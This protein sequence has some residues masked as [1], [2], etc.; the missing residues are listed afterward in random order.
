MWSSYMEIQIGQIYAKCFVI[1]CLVSKTLHADFIALKIQILF[2]L[3]SSS[4]R[5]NRYSHYS[6]TEFWNVQWSILNGINWKSNL[7]PFSWNTGVIVEIAE[8]NNRCTTKMELHSL[9]YLGYCK[10]TTCLIPKYSNAQDGY[11]GQNVLISDARTE[12]KQLTRSKL[13]W[14]KYCAYRTHMPG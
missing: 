12:T 8:W 14:P 10:D 2:N 4:F 13:F 9:N 1:L 11:F 3:P 7:D 6:F 5:L